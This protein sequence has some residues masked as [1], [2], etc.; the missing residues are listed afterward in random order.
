MLADALRAEAECVVSE[1]DRVV[2]RQTLWSLPMV[3]VC[4]SGSQN[5][6]K[7]VVGPKT[8][9]ACT[10]TLESQARCRPWEAGF[11]VTAG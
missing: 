8:R 9:T 10:V 6:N 4:L 7:N 2:T 11:L 3:A 1:F 5:E